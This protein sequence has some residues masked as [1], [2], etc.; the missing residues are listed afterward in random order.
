MEAIMEFLA[1]NWDWFIVLIVVVP[2]L[3]YYL[4]KA[5][6]HCYGRDAIRRPDVRQSGKPG[7]SASPDLSTFWHGSDH[8]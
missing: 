2:L 8:P 1:Q 6:P 4:W 7:Q 5:Q 3:G